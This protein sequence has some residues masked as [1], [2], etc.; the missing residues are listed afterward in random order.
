MPG[1]TTLPGFLCK[2]YG[3]YIFFDVHPSLGRVSLLDGR[4]QSSET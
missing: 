4:F 3:V 1:G 2:P